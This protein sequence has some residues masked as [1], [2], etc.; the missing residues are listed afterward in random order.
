MDS[1]KRLLFEECDTPA[2]YLPGDG[3]E[4]VRAFLEKKSEVRAV[5][6]DLMMANMTGAEALRELL[7]HDPDVRVLVASGYSVDSHT[8]GE[9]TGIMGSL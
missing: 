5:V 9:L 8:G 4:A 2:L 3:A 1:L 6:L 7:K